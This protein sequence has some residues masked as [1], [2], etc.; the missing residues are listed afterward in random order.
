MT[1]DVII[2]EIDG[3]IA[4]LTIN[5]PRKRN[6]INDALLDAGCV[7]FF[8]KPTGRRSR[9]RCAH[10]RGRAFFGGARPVRANASREASEVL[11]HSRGWHELMDM[12]QF[13]G[14]PVV[15]VLNGAVMGGGLEIACAAHVRVAEELRRASSFPRAS[16]ASS[17]AA[18]P[19]FGLA[20]FSG[21][22][23]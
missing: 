6:A 13:G 4:R 18:A 9:R 22:T 11:K 21:P 12:I 10:R 23:V 19:P 17:S 8:S 7:P 1:D 20:A 5:R 3:V 2:T 14:L 16:A 15:A